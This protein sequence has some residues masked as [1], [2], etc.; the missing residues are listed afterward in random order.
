M[1]FKDMI[2]KQSI[3]Y[4]E[5]ALAFRTKKPCEYDD[6]EQKKEWMDGYFDAVYLDQMTGG[7][8]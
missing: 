8:Q 1:N 7:F 3:P 4:H 5:G 6:E 2:R